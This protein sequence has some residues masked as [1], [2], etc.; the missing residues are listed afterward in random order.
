[1]L[2]ATDETDCG[3]FGGEHTL[4]YTNTKGTPLTRRFDS[5]LARDIIPG[6]PALPRFSLPDESGMGLFASSADGAWDDDDDA[7]ETID[8]LDVAKTTQRVALDPVRARRVLRRASPSPAALASP[9]APDADATSEVQVEDILLE[10]YAE[11]PPPR[12]RRSLEIASAPPRQ[13]QVASAP[14]TYAP[15]AYAQATYAPLRVLDHGA[16]PFPSPGFAARDEDSHSVAPVAFPSISM[17]VSAPPAHVTHEARLAPTVAPRKARAATVVAGTLLALTTIALGLGVTLSVRTG[18]MASWTATPS[19]AARSLASK[20]APVA[21]APPHAA[22]PAAPTAP[23]ASLPPPAASI[24]STTS[25]PSAPSMAVDALP[26]SAAPA[27]PAGFT[28]LVF[29]A[30]AQGHRVF[31]D[32]R[33]LNAETPQL[34]RCGRH[35]IRIGSHG[36]PRVTDLACGTEQPL[37]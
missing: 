12:T 32:G 24:A 13:A 5:P 35:M 2:L 31:F 21:A 4:N 6:P 18:A 25:P 10:A 7:N 14:P 29:P 37:R 16:R 1:M 8:P 15:P 9:A 33:P 23:A 3:G 26:S 20:A 36:K 28:R 30:S 19:Q 34:V 22:P 11:E 17:M 27:V